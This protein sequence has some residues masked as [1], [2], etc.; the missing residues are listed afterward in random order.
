M[1][2][3]VA[4]WVVPLA[5]DIATFEPTNW[6]GLAAILFGGFVTLVT[7][8][9]A[10]WATLRARKETSA[11]TEQITN[12][13]KNLFRDDFDSLVRALNEVRDDLRQERTDR[14]RDVKELRQDIDRRFSE[15]NRR[16]G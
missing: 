6:Y 9:I 7:S 16:L 2:S 12:G 3:F 1:S 8:S 11:L 4:D 5:V 13:H 15:L 10:A 14:R